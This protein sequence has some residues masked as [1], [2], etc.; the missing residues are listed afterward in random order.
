MTFAIQDIYE[1]LEVS[2]PRPHVLLVTINRPNASNAMN[3]QLGIE[4]GQV[5]EAIAQDPGDARCVVLTGA[6]KKAFCAGGDLK[7]RNGMTDEAWSY[8]H[9]IFERMLRNLIDCPTPV[10][11]AINGAA[12]GGG[13]EIA[14]ACDFL[15]G[16]ETARFAQTEVGLGIMPGAGGTQ[17]LARAVGERRAKELI[18]SAKPFSAE[19]ALQWGLLNE[20]YPQDVLLDES[21]NIAE[22]IAANAPIA[23]RQAKQAIHRGLQMSLSDGLWFEIEAYNRT[24]PTQDRLEGVQAFNEKRKPHF[25]GS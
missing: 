1:T 21:L 12:Y 4:L 23:V 17:N 24:V 11:G 20:V 8:Q 7:E 2:K 10:I 22:R 18:L 25:N 16:S 5:F 6:G 3:T 19:Q 15:Y 14:A 13:C 9:R